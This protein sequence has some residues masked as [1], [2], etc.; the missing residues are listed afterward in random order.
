MGVSAKGPKWFLL[1]PWVGGAHV[2]QVTCFGTNATPTA[3]AVTAASEVLAAWL[4]ATPS[5]L[6]LLA[7]AAALGSALFALL[8]PWSQV[9]A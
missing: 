4:D 2:T 9:E 6:E 1:E 5:S 8:G 7:A 3:K